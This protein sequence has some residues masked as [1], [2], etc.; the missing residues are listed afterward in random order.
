MTIDN[1]LSVSYFK[2]LKNNDMKT[3]LIKF[4]ILLLAAFTIGFVSCSDDDDYIPEDIVVKAFA[5]KYPGVNKVEWETKRDYK[6]AEFILNNKECEAWFDVQ[7]NWLL[8][9]TDLLLSDL[10][11]AIQESHTKGQ[12]SAWHVD[13]IDM[14]ERYNMATVYI[15]EVEKG[16]TDIDLY[17]AEDGQ[18]IKEVTEGTG[19]PHYPTEVT[20]AINDFINEKYAGAVILE[21]DNEKYGVEVDILHNNIYKDVYF[22]TS[23]EWM[24]T[25][26]DIRVI[27]V[28][29][30]VMATVKSSAYGDYEIDDVEIHET[31]EGILYVFE[32][33][34]GESEV[35]L[36]VKEDGTI[37][38]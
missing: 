19:E 25:E 22:N 5:D 27:D 29:A 6:V 38:A 3:R 7:G 11:L 20:K 37:K 13:D 12:Y 24:R 36:S 32:L 17:Y 26:W 9:E 1:S 10:P 18:L 14:I 8:T 4:P 2:H 31:P 30:V 28:P 15:I 21:Y 16:E 35:Y 23:G 33:E 34:K